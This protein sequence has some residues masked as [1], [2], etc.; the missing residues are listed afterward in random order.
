MQ[1]HGIKYLK[2]Y[3]EIWYIGI[4]GSGSNNRAK[5]FFFHHTAV[6]YKM[7]QFNGWGYRM[8]FCNFVYVWF[9]SMRN[10]HLKHTILFIICTLNLHANTRSN[11]S[12]YHKMK[13]TNTT[14]NNSVFLLIHSLW[15][16]ILPVSQ[17][18]DVRTSIFDTHSM[19]SSPCT[20]FCSFAHFLTQIVEY[21]RECQLDAVYM[22]LCILFNHLS[23]M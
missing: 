12:V 22:K 23:G 18:H 19:N 7:K 9:Y 10:E 15:K 14:T 4:H 6:L 3:E 1:E 11:I 21:R 13:T 8:I 20:P 2:L 16:G 5:N 17:C